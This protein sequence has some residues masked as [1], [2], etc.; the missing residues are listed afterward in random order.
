[1]LENQVKGVLSPRAKTI[2][3]E[4]QKNQLG[5]VL[6]QVVQFDVVFNELEEGRFSIVNETSIKLMPSL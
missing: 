4:I 1:M 6:N 5:I 3:S 2:Q